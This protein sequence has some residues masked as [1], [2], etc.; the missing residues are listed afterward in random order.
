M[1]EIYHFVPKAHLKASENL[2]AFVESCRSQ[3]TVFGSG[4]NFDADIWEI[5]KAAGRRGSSDAIRITFCTL[6]T[7]G[8]KKKSDP[9]AEPFKSFA[10]AHIRYQQGLRPTKNQAPRMA[11][12]RVLEQIL[13]EAQG[14]TAAGLSGFRQGVGDILQQ[15]ALY[16]PQASVP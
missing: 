9:M 14:G 11:A 12:L 13:H 2:A 4:L 1:S 3:L 6:A 16:R 5:T 7:A 15:G 8:W 10:K